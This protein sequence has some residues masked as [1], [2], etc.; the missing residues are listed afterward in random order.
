[1]PPALGCTK[2][3]RPVPGEE[4]LRAGAGS[5]LLTAG[6]QS[7]AQAEL[8]TDSCFSLGRISEMAKFLCRKRRQLLWA[9]E[10]IVP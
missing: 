5:V 4:P 7:L 6:P 1:M 9:S 2:A 3:T 8:G 10:D